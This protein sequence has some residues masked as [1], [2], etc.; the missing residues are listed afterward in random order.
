MI[1]KLTYSIRLKHLN[2][3]FF[4]DYSGFFPSFIWFMTNYLHMTLETHVDN[5]VA[6]LNY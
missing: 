4:T 6:K 1:P 3:F 2:D 5:A